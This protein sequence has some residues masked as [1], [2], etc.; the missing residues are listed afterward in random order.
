MTVSR[1]GSRQRSQVIFFWKLRREIQEL[2]V[3][4][5]PELALD[6]LFLHLCRMVLVAFTDF[7]NKVQRRM[8]VIALLIPKTRKTVSSCRQDRRV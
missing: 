6:C 4:H 1:F 3:F 8:E 5:V 7:L 2:T